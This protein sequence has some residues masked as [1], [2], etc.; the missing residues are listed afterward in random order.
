MGYYWEE[1][2][3]GDWCFWEQ[4]AGS[5]GRIKCR[6]GRG[7]FR[8]MYS[9]AGMWGCAN[10]GSSSCCA[11]EGY[12]NFIPGAAKARGRPPGSLGFILEEEMWLLVLKDGGRGEEIVEGCEGVWNLWIGGY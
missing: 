10:R 7:G 8:G 11:S 6:S 4:D 5:G 2:I 9:I 12:L 1:G 3:D